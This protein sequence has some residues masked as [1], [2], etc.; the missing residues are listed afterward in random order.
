[1][2]FNGLRFDIPL[3]AEEFERA[4][5]E[6]YEFGPI[7]DCDALFKQHHTRTL[8]DAVFTYLDRKHDGAHEA[9][10]DARATLE[11]FQAMRHLH[12]KVGELFANKPT[13]ACS[14]IKIAAHF[15]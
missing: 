4:G 9:A 5:I 6:D 10:A 12:P 11:V 7:I 8:S 3:L 1:M 2:T 14:L 13:P 15:G